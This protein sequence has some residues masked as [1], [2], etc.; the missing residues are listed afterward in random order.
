LKEVAEK[1]WTKDQ[2]A[3]GGP[4]PVWRPEFLA[5]ESEKTISEFLFWEYSLCWTETASRWR[6]CMDRAVKSG[7]RGGQEVVAALD[8]TYGSSA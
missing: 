7:M 1:D 2:W 8:E 3:Q 6:G 5:G 4:G